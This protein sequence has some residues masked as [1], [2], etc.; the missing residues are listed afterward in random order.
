MRESA[1][2][3]GRF[4]CY[5]A[6]EIALRARKQ[7]SR[8]QIT[9][10]NDMPIAGDNPKPAGMGIGLRNV[11][12]RLRARFQDDGRFTSGPI[13]RDRNRASIDLPWR[14]A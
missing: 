9:V 10:E 2:I 5:E 13:A 8:I 6:V 12:D 7:G 14:T 11:A 4:F 1:E 3:D